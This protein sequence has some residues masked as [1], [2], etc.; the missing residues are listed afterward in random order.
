MKTL[1][2]IF[3]LLFIFS[4]TCFSQEGKLNK[5]KKSLTEE[6]DTNIGYTQSTSSSTNGNIIS[7]GNIFIDII[8]TIAF[9]LSYGI[10]IESPP[11][12]NTK[13]HGAEI[14]E[15]PFKIAK[16][17]NYLYTDSTNYKLARFDI[18]NNFIIENKNLYGND[19]NIDFRFLKRMGI[20][21]DYLQLFEKVGG[22][23]DKLSIFSA[24][25]NYHRVRTQRVDFWFGLGAMYV[26]NTVKKVG[27]SYGI[28]GEWFIKKPIS[29][30]VSYKGSSIN[31]Q[32]VN[33]TKILLKYHLKNYH[34]SSGYQHFTIGVTSINAFSLGAGVSF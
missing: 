22:I 4:T 11:E 26:G 33:K 24:M 25:V 15:Y 1:F 28:G 8:G 20:E 2:V 34:I 7:S 18:S 9:Y 32:A 12:M 30:M 27:F 16:S 23:T 3:I 17:G 6:T 13:M 21:V 5:A 10:L 14:S 29:L 31:Q 19:L